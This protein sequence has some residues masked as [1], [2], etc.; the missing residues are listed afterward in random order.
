VQAER[1]IERAL[2]LAPDRP[3]PMAAWGDWMRLRGEYQ[4]ALQAYGRA[5]GL[6]ADVEKRD[7]TSL[8]SVQRDLQASTGL[9][10]CGLASPERARKALQDAE[11]LLRRGHSRLTRLQLAWGVLYTLDAGD[12]ETVVQAYDL[13]SQL[14]GQKDWSALGAADLLQMD[15][16]IAALL[17]GGQS[18][19]RVPRVRLQTA[20]VRVAVLLG[21]AEALDLLNALW[22]EVEMLG[23]EA[24]RASLKALISGL[25]ELGWLIEDAAAP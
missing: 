19:G 8:D 11:R 22:G 12:A 14:G 6:L 25:D 23:D 9:A 2:A 5:S 4:E 24:Q 1:D 15:S 21:A 17:P 18:L 13:F 16:A 20:R 10:Y 7:G 3:E